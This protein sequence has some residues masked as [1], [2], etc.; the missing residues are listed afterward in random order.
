G[1]L[2]LLMFSLYDLLFSRAERK[3]RLAAVTAE[4]II[5]PLGFPMMVGPATLAVALVLTKQYGASTVLIC[6]ALNFATNLLLL[7]AAERVQQ[8]LGPGSMR[9]FGKVMG[10]VLVII[11]VAMIRAGVSGSIRGDQTESTTEQASMI[12]VPMH[13]TTAPSD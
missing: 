9:A 8:K 1:G 2:I 7:L 11:A 6:L 5:I 4:H 13:P 3:E 12:G 10:L